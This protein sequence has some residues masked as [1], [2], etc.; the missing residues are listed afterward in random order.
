MIMNIYK[1]QPKVLKE[2][3]INSR[4]NILYIILSILIIILAKNTQYYIPWVKIH[5]IVNGIP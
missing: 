3:C 5:F 4:H 2:K 1:V